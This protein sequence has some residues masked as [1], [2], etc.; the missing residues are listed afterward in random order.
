[1]SKPETLNPLFKKLIENKIAKL[2]SVVNIYGGQTEETLEKRQKQHEK[3]D[4]KFCNMT[5]TEIFSSSKET[6]VKQINLAETY[7]IQLL[8]TTYGDK[9][10]NEVMVG[11]GGQ[12]HNKGDDHKIYIMYK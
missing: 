2:P 12:R 8:Y 5:I 1:M 10:L 7:L 6:Q 11:G 3:K 9:C 4:N